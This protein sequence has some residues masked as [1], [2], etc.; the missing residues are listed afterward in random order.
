MFWSTIL[1]VALCPSE[2]IS[3]PQIRRYFFIAFVIFPGPCLLPR[4]SVPGV[5]TVTYSP[6]SMT[7][8]V[9]L[10]PRSGH[11]GVY[12]LGPPWDFRAANKNLPLPCIINKASLTR[13]RL[14]SAPLICDKAPGRRSCLAGLKGWADDLGWPLLPGPAVPTVSASASGQPRGDAPGVPDSWGAD[15]ANPV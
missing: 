1:T 2:L 3:L 5:H 8:T 6:V 7:C 4:H 12:P 15:S 11:T 13:K 14:I 10:L 9:R